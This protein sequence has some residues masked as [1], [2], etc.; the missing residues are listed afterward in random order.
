[1]PFGYGLSYTTFAYSDLKISPVKIAQND[2]VIVY[3]TIKNTGQ[4]AGDEVVQLYVQDE[5][6]SVEREVKSLKGFRRV[7]LKPGESKIVSFKLDKNALSFYD[8]KTDKW[9][10]E[11]GKFNVLLGS[12]SRDIRLTGEFSLGPVEKF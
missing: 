11:P 10:A 4:M 5:K 2:T 7:R 6:A 12:S 1:F 8:V 9:K 3:A